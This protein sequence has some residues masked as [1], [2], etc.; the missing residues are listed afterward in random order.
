[1]GD[2]PPVVSVWT[3]PPRERKP[4]DTLSRKQIVVAA[5]EL[6]DAEGIDALSMRHLGARLNAGATSLYWH[7][8]SK[9][10]LVELVVDEIYGEIELPAATRS[11]ADS[12]ANTGAD[13]GAGSGVGSEAD[14]RAVLASCAVSVRTVL[15]RHSWIAGTLG[16]AGVSYLGPN[17]MRLMDALLGE[18]VAAGFELAE[19]DYALAALMSYVVGVAGADAAVLTKVA[20]SG[21]S[22]QEWV[23]SMLPAAKRAAEPYPHLRRLYH[24]TPTGTDMAALN[25]SQFSYGLNLILD[26]LAARLRN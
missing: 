16:E 5:V 6:L 3:R 24:A 18:L 21:Q 8:A 7:V 4:K 11:R 15:L 17:M 14:W 25:E 22:E 9:E 1:M 20:R 26:G 10:E 19:A 23:N 13:S 2:D 12:G